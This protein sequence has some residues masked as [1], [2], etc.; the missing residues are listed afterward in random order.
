MARFTKKKTEGAPAREAP[1]RSD[2]VR[3]RCCDDLKFFYQ[4]VL[5]TAKRGTGKVHDLLFDFIRLH[6]LDSIPESCRHSVLSKYLPARVGGEYQERWL[7]F[8]SLDSEP[9]IQDGPTGHVSS[10]F[11][12]DGSTAKLWKGV[13]LRIKGEG[14]ETC[15]L[16]PRGHLKTELAVVAKTIWEM[17]RDPRLRH[18]IICANATRARQRIGQI[19]S[20]FE[21]NEMLRALFGELIP[22]KDDSEKWNQSELLLKHDGPIEREA[23]LTAASIDGG[24]AGIHCNRIVMDDVVDEKNSTTAVLC[25]KIRLAVEQ[26]TCVGDPGSHTQDVGTIYNDNDAHGLFFKP[27]YGQSEGSSMLVATL[28]DAKGSSLWPE[29]FTDKEIERRRKKI[30][31]DFTWSCQYYN[32]PVGGKVESFDPAWVRDRYDDVP[33]RLAVE[34]KLNIFVAV[35]PA[36]T[37]RKRSDY[38]AA[39]AMGQTQDGKHLYLLDGLRE[40]LA[41]NQ[42]NAALLKFVSW[43]QDIAL[44]AQVGFRVGFESYSFQIFLKT[45]FEDAARLAGRSFFVEE[46]TP[47]HRDK[48]DRIKVLQTPFAAGRIHLP[49]ALRRVSGVNGREYDVVQEL[50]EEYNRWPSGMHDDIL[51]S[52]AY[53]VGDMAHPGPSAP[54][55]EE[56]EHA[57][58]RDQY[59]REDDLDVLERDPAWERIYGRVAKPARNSYTRG[60]P[61]RETATGPARY[62]GLS[63]WTASRGP[64]FRYGSGHRGS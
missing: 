29:V 13:I 55:P 38:T 6:E 56:P 7:Y 19:K 61:E 9:E 33:A 21:R 26:M 54:L 39:V 52:I 24:N 1:V 46:L 2:A 42:I 47:K 48:D 27:E 32:Q 30:S 64:G 17:C 18:V 36:S 40:R 5:D 35:D 31:N 63:V 23:T 8:P 11:Y 4:E 50:M 41:P 51:D 15:T 16:L 3:Q 34:K 49:K 60:N 28:R 45:G 22:D 43:W 25:E 53:V 14:K 57:R 20:I 44:Q 59:F 12:G 62:R 37:T 10:M 58:C